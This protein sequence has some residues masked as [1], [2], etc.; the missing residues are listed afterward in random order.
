M[1]V[2]S[3]GKARA[4]QLPINQ[5][6][7][8]ETLLGRAKT[9][10]Q[11]EAI[12]AAVAWG[13]P[14]SALNRFA[15]AI[16]SQA[17]TDEQ[18]RLVSHHGGGPALA[19]VFAMSCVAATV[20]AFRGELD[21]LY[22]WATKKAN[23]RLSEVDHDDPYRINGGAAHEQELIMRNAGRRTFSLATGGGAGIELAVGLRWL[24]GVIPMPWTIH[25]GSRW[26][27]LRK[28]DALL[29]AGIPVPATFRNKRSG[30]TMLI[31]PE[32]SNTPSGT[33]RQT[34][35]VAD[36][37]TAR[38]YAVSTR[39]LLRAGLLIGPKWQGQPTY[40][41]DQIA[42]VDLPR[43]GHMGLRFLKSLTDGIRDILHRR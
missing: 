17:D 19:Q 26:K 1:I 16:R 32:S 41:L 15:Q 12:V 3:A 9:A 25:G 37:W 36:P 20:Q 22:A 30:H 8:I 43:E 38:T 10:A 42:A 28:V 11:K 40:R 27:L 18:L 5:R 4:S 35:L 31:V 23:E 39:E 2:I 33:A 24:N 13:H 6:R 34:Y 14:I 7:R 21:P 29:D